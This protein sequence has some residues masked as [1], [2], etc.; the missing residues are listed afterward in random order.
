MKLLTVHAAVMLLA[1]GAASVSA[2]TSSAPSTTLLRHRH[3]FFSTLP[4]EPSDDNLKV[5]RHQVQVLGLN[6]FREWEM[7]GSLDSIWKATKKISQIGGVNAMPKGKVHVQWYGNQAPLLRPPFTP[8]FV[9][10]F[11]L[12][13]TSDDYKSTWNAICPVLKELVG[14]VDCRDAT[15]LNYSS[16]NTDVRGTDLIAINKHQYIHRTTAPETFRAK[17]SALEFLLVKQRQ[18]GSLHT[19][20]LIDIVLDEQS[21]VIVKV[22]WPVGNS[23]RNKEVDAQNA[24]NVFFDERFDQVVEV[25]W[26]YREVTE[27]AHI[28]YDHYLGATVTMDA[29]GEEVRE[30][31]IQTRAPVFPPHKRDLSSGAIRLQGHGYNSTMT[32]AQT[33]HP[34]SVT[35]I[36]SN[37][38]IEDTTAGCDLH[39][40]QVLPPGIFVDPFQL[41][42]LAPEI[43]QSIVFGETD[44]EKPVGVVEG[45]GSL[46]MV[47]V[48]PEDSSA[49]SRWQ[50]QSNSSNTETESK[51]TQAVGAGIF[52]ATVD[53]PMHMRYQPPV[54][55]DSNAT[56]IDVAVP[57]PI[58]AW[59]C[60]VDSSENLAHL[61]AKK[62]FQ[63]PALPLTLFSS[64]V[65]KD[66]SPVDWRF[67]LPDPIPRHYPEAH[68]SVPV[69]RLEDLGIVRVATFVLAAAGTL[70]V[71]LALVK[72]VSSRR[73]AGSKKQD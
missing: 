37:P 21:D 19:P 42:G 11:H 29:E 10:G 25:G 40:L 35:M 16:S 57:W 44:L 64:S 14:G 62:L 36:H 23:N 17:S 6:G 70:M 13:V 22:V 72:A 55:K 49:T 60:P 63:I 3:S 31:M 48:Q 66:G 39:V 33:F 54:A 71:T 1:L 67:L 2:D 61:E 46:V 68:V 5:S 8:T 56:H 30:A 15:E 52:S 32:P 50:A 18:S 41:E 65:S 27:Q 7:R 28:V 47:K 20:A 9:P 43:G 58:V 12:A 59:A 51:S 73:S 53:I 34:H 26:F 24:V 69:G 4:E 45:W 38:Y